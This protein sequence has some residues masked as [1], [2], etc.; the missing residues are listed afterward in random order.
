V[1]LF[2]A[3]ELPEPVVAA[4]VRWQPALAAVRPVASGS[5][6]LTLAFL[7][8]RSSAEASAAAEVVRSVAAPVDG[9]TLGAARWLPPRRPRVLA[10]EVE[11]GGGGLG[12]LQVAVVAGLEAA[13]G[14]VPERRRFLAHVTV[15]R[16]RSRG[17][18]PA[19]G[20]AGDLPALPRGAPFAL[21]ALTLM[22]SKLGG[23]RAAR[24]EPV[25]RVALSP[26]LR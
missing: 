1:R 15:G 5:L 8:E 11:D 18:A 21:A 2:V 4:L 22:R 7:G 25:E 10:V 19:P 17:L 24:Y 6:H 23:G 9:L 12:A 20:A 3:A 13:I 14:F 16:V 26:F